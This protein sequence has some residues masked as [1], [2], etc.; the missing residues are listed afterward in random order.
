M[1]PNSTQPLFQP[2]LSPNQTLPNPYY[3]PNPNSPNRVENYL[4]PRDTGPLTLSYQN[5]SRHTRVKF[6]LLHEEPTNPNPNHN[7]DFNPH[8]YPRAAI[9][10]NGVKNDHLHIYL[11][12]SRP[13]HIKFLGF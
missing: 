12:P 6:Y 10:V 4:C 3:K 7:I 9:Q 5:L 13:T 2:Q 8:S 11:D 1:E